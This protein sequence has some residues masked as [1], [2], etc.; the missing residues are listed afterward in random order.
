MIPKDRHAK[1]YSEGSYYN[2]GTKIK[3]Y[4]SAASEINDWLHLLK[5]N[6]ET[7][8]KFKEYFNIAYNYYKASEYNVSGSLEIY[9]FGRALD[10]GLIDDNEALKEIMGRPNSSKNIELL[11]SVHKYHRERVINMKSY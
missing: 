1:E 10:L 2:S 6:S 3:A 7:D 5:N 9:D 11:T 4:F 8:D